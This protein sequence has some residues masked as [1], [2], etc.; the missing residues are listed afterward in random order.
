M[1]KKIAIILIIAL[2]GLLIVAQ[3]ERKVPS[4][5]E[6]L[7]LKGAG[8]PY[9]SPDGKHVV[10][11]VNQ[12]D[13]KENRTDTE[14]WI[15]KNGGTPFQLTNNPEGSSSGPRWS[16]DSKWIAFTS[17]RGNKNQIHVIRADGGEAFPVTR[18][19]EG[20]GRFE[21]SPDG[22]KIAFTMTEKEEKSEKTRKERYGSYA[23]EDEEYRLTRLWAIG[24]DPAFLEFYPLPCYETDSA[25]KADLC[26]KW[27]EPEPLIDSVDFTIPGLN[28][29]PTGR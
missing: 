15:S 27:P 26:R 9:L 21:W 20:V 19:D 25:K 5:E 8:M 16:P 1:K 3:E 24:F 28:G 13:W 29:H 4:F 18:T 22:K 14:I 11:T 6:V 12:T 7:S 23:V 10:F 2:P 17:E